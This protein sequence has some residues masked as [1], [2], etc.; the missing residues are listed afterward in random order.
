MLLVCKFQLALFVSLCPRDL[1]IW[2]IM[3]TLFRLSPATGAPE[4]GRFIL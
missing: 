1:K 4:A 3:E 2:Q